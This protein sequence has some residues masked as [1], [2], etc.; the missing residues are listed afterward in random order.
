[1]ANQEPS[2]Q[3]QLVESKAEVAKLR[4]SLS[5]GVPT[6]HKDLSLVSLVPR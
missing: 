5:L 1:M 4:D 2:L 3:A 6:V